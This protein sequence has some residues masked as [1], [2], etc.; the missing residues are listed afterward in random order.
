MLSLV[1]G[2]VNSGKTWLMQHVLQQLGDRKPPPAI[3]ALNMRRMPFFNVDSFI[4]SFNTNLQGWYGKVWEILKNVKVQVKTPDGQTDVVLEWKKNPPELTDL[5]QYISEGL[6][7]WT[8]WHGKNIP[9]PI[10]FIDE[11]N[12][13]RDLAMKDPNGHSIIKSIFTWFVN[14]I[15]EE[16]KFHVILSSSDSFVHNWLKNLV[17]TDRFGGPPVKRRSEGVLAHTSCSEW[18]LWIY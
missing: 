10:L 8:I 9:A 3:L 15:K 17:G 13:L 12:L 1:T 2:P 6:P 7:D 18:I 11:V 5:F 14:V 16:R 4:K